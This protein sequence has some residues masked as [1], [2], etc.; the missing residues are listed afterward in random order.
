MKIIIS[1]L[2]IGLLAGCLKTRS[3]LKDDGSGN[4]R[5]DASGTYVAGN[6]GQQQRAQIDSRFFEIDRDF[7]ELYGKIETLEKKVADGQV[8][9][10]ATE[11]TSKPADNEKVAALEKRISTLE[12]ALLAIDKKLTEVSKGKSSNAQVIKS[13]VAP[14]GPFGKGELLFEQKNYAQAITS[15][16]TYRKRFPRGRKYAQATLKMGLCFERLKMNNDAKAFY[17]EVIQRYPNTKVSIR[18]EANLKKL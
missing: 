2:M 13:T 7:R 11:P 17:K 3:E 10:T 4:M 12:E 18:A 14:K 6:M 1:I 9:Q 5:T 8:P 16:D 15:F